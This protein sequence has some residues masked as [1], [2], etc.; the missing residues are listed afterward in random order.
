MNGMNEQ[1][2]MWL[3]VLLAGAALGFI[4]FGGLWWT[5][6]RAMT[7]RWVGLWFFGSMLLRTALV[8][9]G[10]YYACGSEW[11]R[12]LAALLGFVV[13]RLVVTRL[14]QSNAALAEGQH[15]S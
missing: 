3:A 5:V 7:S 9:A 11:S 13:A 15:A 12:W 14:T 1:L 8:L 4:F 10:F 2:L 6:R